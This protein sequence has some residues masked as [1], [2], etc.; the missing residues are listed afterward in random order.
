MEKVKV[1]DIAGWT[2]KHCPEKEIF[3]YDKLMI[4]VGEKGIVICDDEGVGWKRDL[5]TDSIKLQFTDI[6]KEG[7]FYI[8]PQYEAAIQIGDI[9]E[10]AEYEEMYLKEFMTK[11]N[12]NS[13]CQQN[14]REILDSM[15]QAGFAIKDYIE[16]DKKAI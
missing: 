15:I 1:Y 8:I 4:L 13:R 14:F 11:W 2:K 10:D 9:L 16:A 6:P 3:R 12:Y 5:I 7:E